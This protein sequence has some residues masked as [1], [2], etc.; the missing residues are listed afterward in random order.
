VDTGGGTNEVAHEN[1]FIKK[2]AFL[3]G[4]LSDSH[5]PITNQSTVSLSVSAG[6]SSTVGHPNYRPP[7]S[8]QTPGSVGANGELKSSRISFV[9]C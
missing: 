8:E 9:L 2:T 7:E 3:L 6:P 5:Q 1:G 4:K